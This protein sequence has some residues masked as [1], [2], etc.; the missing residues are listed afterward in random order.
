[1]TE[2]VGEALRA[3]REAAGVPIAKLA[4]QLRFSESHLRSAENGNRK[5]T[6]DVVEGYDK[7][8]GTGGLLLDLLI[9]DEGGD[10]MR[11][12]VVL[13]VLGT[14]TGL[15]FAGSQVIAESLR[16]SLLSAIGSEDWQEVATEYGQRFLSDPPSLFRS[17]LT[18]D[19]LVL[20]QTILAKGSATSR[21]A[22]P[23]LMMLHGM[24]MA[25]LGDAVGAARWLPGC[26]DHGRWHRR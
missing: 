8:L 26:Q 4:R 13:G 10:E 22:A 1:M 7:A 9:A 23:R 17:R 19:L 24:I 18:G 6:R 11:R 21:L 20:R 2:T 5:I 15:G 16:E 25:N 3:T 14:I 12:R